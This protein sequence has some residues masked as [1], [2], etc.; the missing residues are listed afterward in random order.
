MGRRGWTAGE[1]VD[2]FLVYWDEHR[3]ILRTRNLAAQEGDQRFRD[4]RN[5]SLQPITQALSRK[6]TQNA[7]AGIDPYAAAAAQPGGE[8][9]EILAQFSLAEGGPAL[10]V[11]EFDRVLQRYDMDLLGLVQLVQ[12]RGLRGRLA[13]AGA[14]RDKNDAELFLH[15]FT[16]NRRQP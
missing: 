11:E 2:G 10:R 8:V 16:K 15:H 7:V 6:V 5:Q 13:A 1:L 9:T 14:A 12:H 4:V 3:A